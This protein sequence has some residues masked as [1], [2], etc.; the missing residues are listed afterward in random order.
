[1]PSKRKAPHSE[2]EASYA[3][4]DCVK[5]NLHTGRIVDATI[6]AIIDRSDGKRLQV[7]QFCRCGHGKTIHYVTAAEPIHSASAPSLIFDSPLRPIYL[8]AH[9]ASKS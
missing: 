4:G 7:E 8:C 5:V 6:K 9:Q 3:V 1:M 2:Q